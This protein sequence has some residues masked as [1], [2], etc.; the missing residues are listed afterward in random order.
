MYLRLLSSI[1]CNKYVL[2][3]CFA[4]LMRASLQCFTLASCAHYSQ[5]L[6]VSLHDHRLLAATYRMRAVLDESRSGLLIWQKS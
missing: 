3:S 5:G 4:G 6:I 2:Y 1:N